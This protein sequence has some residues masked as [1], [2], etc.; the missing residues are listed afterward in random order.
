MKKDLVDINLTELR[1][2][3][4]NSEELYHTKTSHLSLISIKLRLQFLMSQKQFISFYS[5]YTV[6]SN[7][8]NYRTIVHD[9][10]RVQSNELFRD[11]EQWDLF[12]KEI[13]KSENE[14]NICLFEA[15]NFYDTVTL[16][17]CL[18]RYMLLDKTTL[19]V[20]STNNYKTINSSLVFNE[21][22]IE[23]AIIN[24]STF[25]TNQ[26]LTEYF[27]KEQANKYIYH[28]TKHI[29]VITLNDIATSDFEYD[30]VIARNITLNY[31]FT[32]HEVLF[33]NY[34]RVLKS[35]GVLFTGNKE[36]F[37]WC[38]KFKHLNFSN[39]SIPIYK[40]V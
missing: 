21:K 9:T 6:Y 13:K 7:D 17:I 34:L 30:M 16:L 15:G 39:K 11:A 24:F 32:E 25:D 18:D 40:K 1:E 12:I 37:K 29:N 26:T 3:I 8:E 19:T 20:V 31:N 33:D 36:G 23:T 2:F 10:L 27:T 22:D 38:S 28:I 14:I 4:K 5:F 35:K